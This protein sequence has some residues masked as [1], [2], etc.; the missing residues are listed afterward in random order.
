MVTSQSSSLWQVTTIDLH[1]KTQ[2]THNFSMQHTNLISPHADEMRKSEEELMNL[3]ND[4]E[5]PEEDDAE[6]FQSEDEIALVNCGTTKGNLELRL[7]RE[8]SPHGYDRAVA[9]FER[10]FYDRSHFFR[11]V[12]NFLVQFGISY[13]KDEDLQHLAHRTIPDDPPLR[14]DKAVAFEPG[15]VSFAG[16]YEYCVGHTIYLFYCCFVF[17]SSI[18]VLYAVVVSFLPIIFGAF[19][20]SLVVVWYNEHCKKKR[21]QN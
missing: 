20:L 13:S 2:Q 16:T 15:I 17:I 10:G 7:V 8:W 3:E 5:L 19:S 4:D 14:G 9:L 18:R 21:K 12:P 11:V 1:F 6:H